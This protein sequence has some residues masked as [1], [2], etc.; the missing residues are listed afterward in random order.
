[1]A[2]ARSERRGKL[3]A[4]TALDDAVEMWTVLMGEDRGHLEARKEAEDLVAGGRALAATTPTTAVEPE[5]LDWAVQLTAPQL[6]VDVETGEVVVKGLGD[7]LLS[8][9]GLQRLPPPVPLL[10]GWLYRHTVAAISAP[11]K[12]GKTFLVLEMMLCLAAGIPWVGGRIP[13][14]GKVLYI[15]GEGVSGVGQRVQAWSQHHPGA[16]PGDHIVFLPRAV[17][18][19]DP[20]AAMELVE[21]AAAEQFDAIVIDTL[22]RAAIGMEENSAKE[23][24]QVVGVLDKLKAVSDACVLIVHHTGKDA[25]KGLRGS[26]AIAG[27]I[28]TSLIIEGDIINMHLKTDFQKDAAGDKHVQLSSIAVGSS[29]VL[30]RADEGFERSDRETQA[31]EVLRWGG[32]PITRAEWKDQLVER[33]FGKTLAYDTIGQLISTGGAYSVDVDPSARGA[34][35]LPAT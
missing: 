2:L 26:S 4:T 1:M 35:F 24:G 22:A 23:M 8:Y 15:I 11:P 17:P 16:N 10:E 18:F 31:L 9:D 30:R 29:I 12:S 20:V 34:R 28:D 19:R 3:G 14:R 7:E 25:S 32:V 27:A 33:D 13:H 5:H 21:L 6:E